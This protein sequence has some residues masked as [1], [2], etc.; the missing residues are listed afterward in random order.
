MNRLCSY[1]IYPPP[2]E[3]TPKYRIVESEGT[4]TGRKSIWIE[5]EVIPIGNT[6]TFNIMGSQSFN[7]YRERVFPYWE[8]VLGSH[9]KIKKFNTISKA[10]K[11]IDEIT[12][13]TIL[14]YYIYGENNEGNE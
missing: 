13:Q 11:Y 7:L 14:K 12:E 3:P 2:P 8:S 4:K 10:N 1:T 6:N 9:G 5:K